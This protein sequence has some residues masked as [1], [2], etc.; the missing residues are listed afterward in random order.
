MPNHEPLD[1]RTLRAALERLPT[2]L[3][4]RGTLVDVDANGGGAPIQLRVDYRIIGHALEWVY[5]WP[6]LVAAE[7]AG[8]GPAELGDR[9]RQRVGPR[10]LSV[11]VHGRQGD[12]AS[13]T[14]FAAASDADSRP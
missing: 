9:I 14:L 7:D 1:P 10:C 11:H 3:P 2:S 8:L 4:S 5:E 6:V 13:V 12:R